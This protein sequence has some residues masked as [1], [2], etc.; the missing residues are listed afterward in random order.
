MEERTHATVLPG[1][2]AMTHIDHSVPR[3][4]LDT[5]VCLDLFVFGDSLS[6]H[7]LAAL[8]SGAVQAVTREDCR[9]EWHRVLHY[10]QLP[11][12]DRL[13][14]AFRDAFD[15]WIQLLPPEA[16]MVSG[17]D[18][19]LPRC[20]DPDDQKFLELALASGASWLL[21]KDKELLKLDRRTRGAG[22]FAIRLPQ[23]W[24]IAD[25]RSQVSPAATRS[26]RQ[27]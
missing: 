21:S 18:A 5:N 11:I 22:L 3:I 12:D 4:V 26:L 17:D 25:A 13:R 20:A 14:P 19:R 10:P 15:A 16:S 1:A 23:L 24:S 8:R 9:E 27:S 2:T 7:V 6:S